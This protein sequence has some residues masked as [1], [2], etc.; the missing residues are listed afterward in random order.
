MA[1]A[2]SSGGDDLVIERL[3]EHHDVGA[4]RCGDSFLELTLQEH[5][6]VFAQGVVRLRTPIGETS[7]PVVFVAAQ[8]HE[9]AA[10]VAVAELEFM[11]EG[12]RPQRYL[13]LP[14]L[15]RSDAHPSRDLISRLIVRIISEWRDDQDP[16]HELY[17]GIV[18]VPWTPRVD[19][20]LTRLR[21]APGPDNSGLLR[22]RPFEL[23]T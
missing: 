4:F 12:D 7:P 6:R 11:A 22:W 1:P 10:Y 13:F 2:S 21:F 23:D 19:E 16:T 15:A 8:G 18:C 17:A 3:C 5:Q 14:A 20:M 9:V